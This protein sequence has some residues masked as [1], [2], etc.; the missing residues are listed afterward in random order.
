M[1][2][3]GGYSAGMS[4]AERGRVV[5]TFIILNGLEA[6]VRRLLCISHTN[7]KS[8]AA[9]RCAWHDCKNAATA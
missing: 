7:E 5:Y 4:M 1:I 3:S 6:S 2:I 9:L 8:E